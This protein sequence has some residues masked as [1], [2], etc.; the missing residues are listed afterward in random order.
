MF[1][2]GIEGAGFAGALFAVEEEIDQCGEGEYF[3][4]GSRLLCATDSFIPLAR[5]CRWV[6]LDF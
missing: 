1:E 2:F 4:H 3:E 5:I 6:G